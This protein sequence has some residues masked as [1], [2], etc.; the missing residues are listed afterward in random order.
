MTTRLCVVGGHDRVLG[1][2]H[3]CADHYGDIVDALTGP[4]AMQDPTLDAEWGLRSL[5]RTRTFPS[6]LE[7][8]A[9]LSL[10]RLFHRTLGHKHDAW[11]C[12]LEL[13]ADDGTG[14]ISAHGYRPARIARD[15]AALG[16]R[17]AGQTTGEHIATGTSAEAPLPLD[18]AVAAVR[19]DIEATLARWARRHVG[20]FGLGTPAQTTTVAQLAAF[21]AIHRDR[22]A[23]QDWAGDYA[24]ELRDL[25]RRARKLIDL[26]QPRRVAIAPC[27]E[28]VGG[29]RC[30]GRLWLTPREERDARPV[31]VG[32]DTCTAV[33]TGER[34]KRLSERLVEQAGRMAA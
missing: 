29:V 8:E 7:A 18:V 2:L 32:C 17:L 4:S 25:R 19:F 27:P 20:D 33:Y 31:S 26:P 3:V 10:S 34:W 13:V 16:D 24:E 1:E 11:Y 21:L 14:W 30:A 22:A 15:H 5:G 23:A 12:G 9:Q 6:R 28:T